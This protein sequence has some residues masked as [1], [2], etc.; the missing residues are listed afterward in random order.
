MAEIVKSATQ[1]TGSWGV[2]GDVKGHIF[3][4]DPAATTMDR[5]NAGGKHIAANAMTVNFACGKCHDSAVGSA[6]A[7]ADASAAAA[8]ATNYHATL[9]GIDGGYMG[10]NVCGNCHTHRRQ[11]S[12]SQAILQSAVKRPTRLLQA[13][14]YQHNYR[15]AGATY[16]EM[17]LLRL[18]T[19]EQ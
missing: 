16:A 8:V 10:T 13:E 11:T 18:S 15:P 4:I 17:P 9:A 1:L 6:P 14:R 2:K 5:T 7:L 3:R 19:I 12:T